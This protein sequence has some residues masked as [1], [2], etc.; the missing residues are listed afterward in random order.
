[1]MIASYKRN[2][3]LPNL[4]THLTTT[5]PPSLRQIVIIWQNIGEPLP[6]ILLPDSLESLY[7]A[8]NSSVRVAVRKSKVN[9]M[10][11]R[12]RPALDWGEEIETH[13]VMIH[14][15]DVV[16]RRGVL[17][18]GYQQ[19][20]LA[21]PIDSS[22]EEGKIVGF[23]ARDF[24]K[25]DPVS[26]PEKA[27]WEWEYVVQPKDTYSM[28]LS[29]AAWF[30]KDWFDKYFEEEGEMVTLRDYVD[31][32]ATLSPST[33]VKIPSSLASLLR[34]SSTATTS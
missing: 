30:K 16:L 29:N 34:Q 13:A 20:L 2:H 22:K 26:E 25:I 15:D 32:G 5:P 14:D 21:N 3:L 24:S 10:N 31:E 6:P 17:E 19:F 8:S 9:S 12:F 28:V 11:E 27:E 23:T 33:L 7:F 18:W 1:M 4:L